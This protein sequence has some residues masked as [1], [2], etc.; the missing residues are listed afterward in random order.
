MSSD[1][2]REV[3]RLYHATMAQPDDARAAFLA[4]ACTDETLRQEVQALLEQPLSA[5]GF[6][7]PG[8]FG[9]A[10][11]SLGDDSIQMDCIGPYEIQGLLGAG[12]MGEVYRARDP[13]LGRDVAI[14]ILPRE[15]TSDTN[16]LARF[17]REARILAALNHPNIGAIYGLEDGPAGDADRARALILELV[18][19]VTLED[20]IAQGPLTFLDAVTVATQVAEALAAAHEKGIVHRDLKPANIKITPYGVVKVLDFGLAK[21]TTDRVPDKESGLSHDGL[22]IGTVAYMSPEQTRGRD[23]DTRSDIWAFGCI[24]Y[25]MLVG[26]SAFAGATATD[27]LAAIVEREPD[28][29]ALPE[30]TRPAL[31]RLLKRCLQKEARHRLYAIADARLDLEDALTETLVIGATARRRH[32]PV[33]AIAAVAVAA[34]VIAAA[35]WAAGGRR[36][37]AASTVAPRFV[38]VTFR[39]GTLTSARF[40]PDGDS[41][42]YS[43]AWGVDPYGIFMTR[44]DSVESR[45]LELPNAKLFGV[46]SSGEIAFLRGPHSTLKM[47]SPAAG[48]LSR[49]SIAGGG[50]RELLDDVI[51]AD[52]QPGGTDLAVVR[53]GSVE[54][55]LGTEIF[56]QHRFTY[57]RVAP[58][59]QRLALI[60]GPGRDA[61]GRQ[62]AAAIV[63]LDRAGRKTTLSSGWGD[64]IALAWSPSGHEVWFTATRPEDSSG[65]ALRAVST[66][67]TERVIL[68]AAASLLSIHDVFSDGRVLLSSTAVRVGC[69]CLAPG[70]TQPRDVGWLDG[71]APEALSADGRKVVMAELLRGKG[72]A[73]SI[74][75][76]GTDG[77]D[78]VRLGDGFPEDLSPD[79]K[80]VLAAPVGTRSHWFLLPTGTGV[81]RTLP[82]GPLVERFEANFLPGGQRIVFGGRA[83][84]RRR[85]IFVQDVQ[86]GAV[87]AISPEGAGTEGVATPDGRFVIGGIAGKPFLFPVDGG[88]PVPLPVMAGGDGALQWSSDGRVLYVRRS[89]SW[90][91]VVDRIEIATGRREAWKTIQP[92]DPVGVEA[93]LRILVTPDGKAY[94]HDYVRLLSDLFIVEGLT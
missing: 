32:R 51:A 16:R 1:R 67:G 9:A 6:L 74:Y 42:V 91:P 54:F 55:P 29:N 63:L 45:S 4:Q 47:L 56:G 60:E 59:G 17:E 88:A 52:W 85:Q 30:S 69:S 72:T 70:D 82:P 11:R 37:D 38:P 86:S 12:G 94:C 5:P 79:G 68:P 31:R 81:P 78:A 75:L 15:F 39:A 57:A 22:L 65:S 13:R 3:S 36:G 24:L 28:W 66:D 19:G 76:R 53:R 61:E 18:E 33:T 46:S 92:A 73:G 7:E 84:D 49:V 2:W 43:A 89:L 90:P 50:P 64:L 26:R 20:R 44:R 14:K 25:E 62:V 77:S 83:K 80:W 27:T 71:P 21:M 23:V 10:V 48:T 34:V 87:R 41:I 58:D 40:T 35:V 8:A 93:I